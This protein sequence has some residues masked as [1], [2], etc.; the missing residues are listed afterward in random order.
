M[1]QNVRG[2]FD[3]MVRKI[4][5]AGYGGNTNILSTFGNVNGFTNIITPVHN[6]NGFGD[7]SITIIIA[8]DLS[9][10]TQNAA[11][12]SSQLTLTD[13]NSIFDISKNKYLCLNGENNYLVKSI[14]GNTVTLT[15]PLAEDHLVSEAV[16]LVKAITYKLDKTNPST[17]VLLEDENNGAGSQVLAENI[18]SLNFYY[19]LADGTVTDSPATPADIRMVKTDMVARTDMPNPQLP[20]DGYLRREL[21]SFAQVR[22][23]GL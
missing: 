22:N 8:D 12:G 18:E 9:T 5:M 21:Y 14:S 13:A 7:D 1:Q 20:G 10:L 16:S 17:P 3:Q 11:K 23:L 15:V 4:R 2:S 6:A 19:T